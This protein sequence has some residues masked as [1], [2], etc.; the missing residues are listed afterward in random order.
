M[1]MI[2]NELQQHVGQY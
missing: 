1:Y 2:E